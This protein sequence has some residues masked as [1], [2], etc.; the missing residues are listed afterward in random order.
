M[1]SKISLSILGTLHALLLPGQATLHIEIIRSAV[2]R[3]LARAKAAGHSF[4]T[5]QKEKDGPW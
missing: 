5:H 1:N 2:Q 4:T 3:Q